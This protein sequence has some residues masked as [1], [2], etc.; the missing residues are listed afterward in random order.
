MSHAIA[1]VNTTPTALFLRLPKQCYFVGMGQ[2][3]IGNSAGEDL[4]KKAPSKL[5]V[6]IVYCFHKVTI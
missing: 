6:H 2:L 3:P 1:T 4:A 5:K